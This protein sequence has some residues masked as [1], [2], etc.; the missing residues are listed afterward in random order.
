[1]EK[2]KKVR[3]NVRVVR[4]SYQYYMCSVIDTNLY[5]LGTWMVC[6]HLSK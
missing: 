5:E 1:M 3:E 6:D 2:K 4:V